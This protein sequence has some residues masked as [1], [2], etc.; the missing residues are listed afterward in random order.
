MKICVF[1]DWHVGVIQGNQV[2][3]ITALVD[4]WEPV[5]PYAWMLTFI[6]GFERKRSA[7]EQHVKTAPRRPIS[8]VQ[9]HAPVP[10]PSKVIAAPVNY[11]LHQAEM[12]GTQGV[13]AGFSIKTIEHYGLFL[14][15]SSAIV[16]PDAVITLPFQNRRT[17]HEAEVGVVIGR[18]VKNVVEADADAAIFGITGLLDL[19]VR[20]PEDRPF[21]KGFDGFCPIG[22]VVVTRDEIPDWDDIGFALAVNGLVR[23]QGNTRDMIYGIRRLVSLASY[24]TTLHPGDII[25]SGTPDGVGSLKPGDVM[26]LTVDHVGTLTVPIASAYAEPP[27]DMGDW[28]EGFKIARG[29]PA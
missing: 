14:K 29:A 4:S 24:Q 7:I 13:Y 23:Q 1:D 5:W 9:F 8:E 17:D 22:P 15:P 3:D 20:G 25:A 19:S 6:E 12:G 2:A 16:G 27:A 18:Q 26:Q 11:R 21:R 28:F 10:M